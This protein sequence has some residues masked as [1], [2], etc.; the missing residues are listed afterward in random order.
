VVDQ[1]TQPIDAIIEAALFAAGEPLSIRRLQNLFPWE[2]RISAEEITQAITRLQTACADRG[3]DLVEVASGFRFQAKKEYVVFLKNLWNKKPSKYSRALLETLALIVYRQPITRGEIE[4][5]RGVVPSSQIMKTLQERQ[6]VKIVGVREVAGKPALFATTKQFLDDFNLRS[7]SDL[8]PLQEA[9]DS[10]SLQQLSSQ[11]Q[12][13]VV[14]S[15]EEEALKKE[16]VLE[17]LTVES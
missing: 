15:F 3:V 1:G 10:D 12:L 7:L 4:E 16:E 5:I 13:P 2:E 9:I 8:P 17:C 11:L 6:W 14:S